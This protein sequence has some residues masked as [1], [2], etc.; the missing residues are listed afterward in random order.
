MAERIAAKKAAAEI[1]EHALA[2][3]KETVTAAMPELVTDL[4][5]RAIEN[6]DNVAA[7][8]L[9]RHGLPLSSNETRITGAEHL[10]DMEP[11]ARLVEVARLVASGTIP[12]EHGEV[13][14]KLAHQELEALYIRPLKAMLQALKSGREIQEALNYLRDIPLESLTSHADEPKPLI[15]NE[16]ATD[17]ESV[18]PS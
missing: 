13:L 17:T 10:A 2:Q 8:L 12:A 15:D 3:A 6:G 18:T 11:E 5:K 1:R 4:R 16:R 14:S 7:G 9:L